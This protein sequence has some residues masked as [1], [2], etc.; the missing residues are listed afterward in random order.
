M[1]ERTRV[2]VLGGHWGPTRR[3]PVVR[4]DL[5]SRPEV[6]DLGRLVLL[7][8]GSF[9]VKKRAGVLSRNSM[10]SFSALT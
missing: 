7:E 9:A 8:A 5:G 4:V 3:R 2:D 1:T 10:P 6:D